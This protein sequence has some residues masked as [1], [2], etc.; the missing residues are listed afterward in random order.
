MRMTRTTTLTRQK[1]LAAAAA[2]LGG[3]LL[4]SGCGGSSLDGRYVTR[5]NDR[6][7]VLE[8]DGSSASYTETNCDGDLNDSETSSGELNESQ[9]S[10]TWIDTGGRFDEEATPITVT[11]TAIDIA[12]RSTFVTEDSDAG[13]EVQDGFEEHCAN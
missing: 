7:A 8:I 13:Q 5:E 1:G 10:I 11:E 6:Y 4:L 12:D 2:L 3:T 9:T